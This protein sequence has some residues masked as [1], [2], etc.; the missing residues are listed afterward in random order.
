M[1]KCNGSVVG[2]RREQMD[3]SLLPCLP[4]ATPELDGLMNLRCLTN[5]VMEAN[6]KLC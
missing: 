1:N 5:L 3:S 2:E 4:C 6:E